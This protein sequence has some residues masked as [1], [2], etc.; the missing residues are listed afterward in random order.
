MNKETYVE[1]IRNRIELKIHNHPYMD[2]YPGPIYV[3]HEMNNTEDNHEPL[4]FLFNN[5]SITGDHVRE[6]ENLFYA[7]MGEDENNL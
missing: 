5:I 3:I 6:L 7:L 1:M 4:K 2:I